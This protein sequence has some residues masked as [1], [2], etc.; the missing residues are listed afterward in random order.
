[1]TQCTKL[2]ISCCYFLAKPAACTIVNKYSTHNQNVCTHAVNESMQNSLLLLNSSVSLQGQFTPAS[3]LCTHL[4][5]YC[6]WQSTILCSLPSQLAE[7]IWIGPVPGPKWADPSG[8]APAN[9]DNVFTKICAWIYILLV[10]GYP[11]CLQVTWASGDPQKS[12]HTVPHTEFRHISTLPSLHV[13]PPTSRRAPSLE[14]VSANCKVLEVCPFQI[15]IA[16]IKATLYTIYLVKDR[17]VPITIYTIQIDVVLR[18]S[19]SS[20]S[21]ITEELKE[22]WRF[23]PHAI[24]C[25]TGKLKIRLL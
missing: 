16:Y 3:S 2:C 12:S 11:S 24:L 7:R 19:I 5:S 10:T 17:S 20:G 6:S 9:K 1:M 22:N 15:P 18:C 4:F 23:G 21:H 14:H 8:I 13:D 25:G